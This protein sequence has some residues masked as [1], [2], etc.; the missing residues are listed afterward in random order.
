MPDS[1]ICPLG[2]P[3]EGTAN[4]LQLV[5][6][7]DKSLVKRVHF[8]QWEP[9]PFNNQ[10]RMQDFCNAVLESRLYNGHTTAAD[11]MYTEVTTVTLSNGSNMGSRV[12]TSANVVPGTP[13]LNAMV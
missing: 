3:T 9:S 7:F 13:E 12:S 11:A 6:I 1:I 4:I 5:N 10:R 8:L 2:N